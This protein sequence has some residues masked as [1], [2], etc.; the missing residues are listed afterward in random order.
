MEYVKIFNMNR[1]YF[2]EVR[3]DQGYNWSTT[4]RA[5]TAVASTFISNIIIKI[6]SC[7]DVLK[8]CL[9]VLSK[10]FFF[11]N[12]WHGQVR[13]NPS[14]PLK[15]AP[16]VNNIAK[17]KSDFL[18]T[19]QG[20]APQSREILQKLCLYSLNPLSPNSDQHQFSPNNIHRLSKETVMRINKMIIE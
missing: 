10:V 1:L 9:R 16:L 7:G 3:K 13:E 2:K 15:R 14:T 19:N 5:G 12:F 18:K 17:R 4:Y 6:L 11:F 8:W 20:I